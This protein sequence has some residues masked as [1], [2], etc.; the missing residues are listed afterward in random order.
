MLGTPITRPEV[1]A[2]S[3]TQDIFKS[4]NI[5]PYISHVKNNKK[6]TCTFCMPDF[7]RISE[8]DAA[9]YVYADASQDHIQY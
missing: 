3:F 2:P 5:F 4:K 9:Q 1:V 6:E 8:M 7:T